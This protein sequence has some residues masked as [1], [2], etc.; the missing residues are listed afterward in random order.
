[1]IRFVVAAAILL[2]V[3]A[4]ADPTTTFAGGLRS[5]CKSAANCTA[6]D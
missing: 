5:W 3:S 1:M 4:C 6:Q 2:A